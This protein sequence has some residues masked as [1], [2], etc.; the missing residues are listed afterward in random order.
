MSGHSKWA[1]I[2]RQKETTDAK[3]GQGFTKISSAI[4][5]AIR[6][7]GGVTDPDKNFKLRLAIEKGRAINMP[8]EN[9]ERAI[10]R[11]AGGGEGGGFEEITYEGYGPGGVA[12][13][14]EAATDN[15]NRTVQELKNIFERG[16]GT[17]ASQGAV[18]YQFSPKGLITVAKT[19]NSEETIL[20]IID[21]GVEDVEEE[22][23]AIEVYTKPE[24]LEQVRVKL[25]QSGFEIKSFE[26]TMKPNTVVPIV[27]KDTASKV[28]ALME[29]LE[30]HN[31]VQRVFANFDIPQDY[32]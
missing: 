13:M 3:R 32:V 26:L 29:R 31:D 12:I 8:K 20:K 5:V 23:D 9:V 21:L 25:Q 17:L 11:A 28:L 24:E 2:H 7:G 18:A 6:S 1:T 22:E 27:E 10:T 15:K 16:G 30:E 4:I 14:I 19:G